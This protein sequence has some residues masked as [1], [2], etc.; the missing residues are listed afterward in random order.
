[1]HVM[2]TSIHRP[3]EE[4]PSSPW[5]YRAHLLGHDGYELQLDLSPIHDVVRFGFGVDLPLPDVHIRRKMRLH[6]CHI[7]E[8]SSLYP[9]Y[10]GMITAAQSF[11]LVAQTFRDGDTYTVDLYPASTLPGWFVHRAGALYQV[12]GFMSFTEALEHL[13]VSN[14]EELS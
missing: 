7:S 1:M 10:E 12:T 13:V 3:D 9:H 5:L 2:H 4:Y 11:P 14:S 8:S 6:G